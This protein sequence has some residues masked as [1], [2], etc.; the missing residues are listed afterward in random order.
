MTTAKTEIAAYGAMQDWI[1][2]NQRS[3]HET[4]W[5]ATKDAV[6]EW[7]SN[8][9]DDMAD[10][11]GSAYGQWLSENGTEAMAAA[12]IAA[13]DEKAT[14]KARRAAVRANATHPRVVHAI[15]THL[16]EHRDYPTPGELATALGM[17]EDE[18]EFKIAVNE[19]TA[20][21]YVAYR[22]RNFH[23]WEHLLQANYDADRKGHLVATWG[24]LSWPTV[25]VSHLV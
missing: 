6:Y 23:V 19:A 10:A 9:K 15:L 25:G 8:N 3:I 4:I 17:S 22:D 1:R 5:E 2:E 24:A 13:K 11:A 14:R 21:G 12:V 20:S 7:L 16:V 18:T